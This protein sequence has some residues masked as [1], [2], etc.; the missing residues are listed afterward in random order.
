MNYQQY[1]DK[2]EYELEDVWNEN[3]V[4]LAKKGYS[5]DSFCQICY[6]DFKESEND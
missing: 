1:M 4:E 6:Q 5:Y 3:R 2:F